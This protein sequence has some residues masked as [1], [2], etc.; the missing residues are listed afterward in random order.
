MPSYKFMSPE[1]LETLLRVVI[2]MEHGTKVPINKAGYDAMCALA[3]ECNAPGFI[4]EYFAY[5][6]LSDLCE[7]TF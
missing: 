6:G 3:Q 4:T 2:E 7:P 5:K 1:Q